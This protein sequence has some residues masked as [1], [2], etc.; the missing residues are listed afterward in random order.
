MIGL[1][2]GQLSEVASER[3]SGAQGFLCV[4]V[5]HLSSLGEHQAAAISCDNGSPGKHS[6]MAQLG[7][8]GRL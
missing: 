7:T 1:A 2:L 4:S 5:E 3:V 6:E 8:D